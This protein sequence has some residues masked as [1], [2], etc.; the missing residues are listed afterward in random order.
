MQPPATIMNAFQP[1]QAGT[2]LKLMLIH[3]KT[4]YFSADIEPLLQSPVPTTDTVSTHQSALA[5]I[6]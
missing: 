6:I 5:G 4:H 1:S 2:T 3:K